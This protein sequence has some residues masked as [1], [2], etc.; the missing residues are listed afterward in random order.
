MFPAR[1]TGFCLRSK[2]DISE[3]SN[4]I[5]EMTGGFDVYGWERCHIRC[6]FV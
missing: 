6:Y 2:L 5:V 3:F 1:T 4:E